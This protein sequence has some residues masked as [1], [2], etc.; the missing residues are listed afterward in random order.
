MNDELSRLAA[1]Y[2]GNLPDL[3]SDSTLL[4]G[5]DYSGEHDDSPYLVFSFLMTTLESWSEW[6]PRRQSV[7]A[8]HLKDSRRMSFKQL[9]DRNRQHALGPLLEAANGLRGLSLTIAV[10]KK[11]PS[12]FAEPSPLDLTNPAFMPYEKWKPSVLTK[13]LFVVHLLGVLLAGLAAPR[14]DVLWFTDEDSIAANDDRLP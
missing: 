14:Q 13:A 12:F 3:R 9:R 6:E 2:E 7:R 10:N 8:V 11:C 5:S 1:K 4:L